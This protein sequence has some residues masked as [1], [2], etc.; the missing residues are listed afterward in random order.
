MK[1]LIKNVTAIALSSLIALTSVGAF[2]TTDNISLSVNNMDIQLKNNIFM[3]DDHIMIPVRSFMEY[4]DY[5]VDWNNETGEIILLK[6]DNEIVLKPGSG[7]IVKNGEVTEVSRSVTEL[8]GVS[9]APV[10]I[11]KAVADTNVI[12]EADKNKLSLLSDELYTSRGIGSVG[13]NVGAAVAENTDNLLVNGSFEAD[14]GSLAEGWTIRRDGTNVSIDSTVAHTG[15]KSVKVSKSDSSDIP[16][17]AYDGFA[18]ELAAW[19]VGKYKITYWVKTDASSNII[20]CLFRAFAG[21]IDGAW[22]NVEMTGNQ[23]T[24]TSGDGWKKVE[25]TF[26]LTDPSKIN[27]NAELCFGFTSATGANGNIWFDDI[28]L[29]KVD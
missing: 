10:S 11:I 12:W 3:M 18:D 13:G 24:I 15:K 25:K 26:E 5:I 29:T 1:K 22:S 19:G 21:N 20:M 4:Y 23:Q 14:G 27:S 8:N 2:A 7:R 28:T 6:G 9:Y 17:V 16:M